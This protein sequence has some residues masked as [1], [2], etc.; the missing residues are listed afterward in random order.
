MKKFTLFIAVM[1]ITGLMSCSG[2]QDP[3][4]EEGAAVQAP[5]T[6]TTAAPDTTVK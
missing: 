3:A 1:L 2:K 5:D 6:T 4:L